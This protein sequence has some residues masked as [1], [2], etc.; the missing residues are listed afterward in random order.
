M[1]WSLVKVAIFVSLAAVLAFGATIIQDTPGSV[2]ISFGDQERSLTPL[3]FLV[4]I[5]FAFAAFWLLLKLAGLLVAVLR[6]LAGDSTA[7]TRFWDKSRERRGYTALSEGLIA[8]ASGEGQKA[9]AK[10]NKAEKLLHKPELTLLL[11]AQAAEMTG[12]QARAVDLYKQLLTDDRTRF[13]GV[14]GLMKAKLREGDTE[15]ALKLAEKAFELKPRHAETLE[16]LF[17][18]QSNA[19]DWSG[20]RRTL[21]A[22][23]RAKILPKDIATRRD[24]VLSVADAM[25]KHENGHADLAR[26]AAIMA[27]RNAPAL[28]P[29]A[30]LAAQVYIGEG[31]KRNAVRILRKAWLANPHPDLAAAFAGIEPDETAIERVKRF[32]TF[33][34]ILPTHSETRLLETELLLAAEDFPA[35]RRA[36]GDLADEQPTTRTLALMAT[37]SRGEGAAEEVVRGW[38]ARALGA[39]RGE[40]WVCSACNSIHPKWAPTCSNCLGFDTLSWA[41][42]AEGANADLPESMMPL[43]QSVL[44]PEADEQ[45]TDPEDS[46]DQMIEVKTES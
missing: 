37:I 42:P 15:R 30:V 8:V 10:A 25:A 6:T 31:T 46:P 41:L 38:L 27:N 14:R 29:A 33:L 9:V 4:G 17:A 12:D 32:A 18:L 20:A 44:E 2:L 19:S 13:I 45:Q 1:I 26:D 43:L 23:S 39:P 7:M 11:K 36:L 40:Q 5:L 21:L 34:K 22:K 3:V 28:V 24:A 16:T 35:A